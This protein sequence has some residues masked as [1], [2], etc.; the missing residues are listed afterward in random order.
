LQLGENVLCIQT[1]NIN[2]D[3]SDLSCIPYLVFGI[4]DT[5]TVVS[6]TNTVENIVMPSGNFIYH[7]NFTLQFSGEKLI[8]KDSYGKI[9]DK[10]VI[11]S[12]HINN[13]WGR[14]YDGAKKWC[15]FEKPTP[16]E[17][18][19]LSTGYLEYLEPPTFSLLAGFYKCSQLLS[20]K[21]FSEVGEIHYTVDGSAPT[22]LSPV[23]KSPIT[24]D[25]TCVIKAKSFGYPISL[26]STTSTSTYFINENI[27]LPVISLSTNP[28]NLWDYHKGIYVS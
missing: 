15:Y 21:N 4:K 19:N 10:K 8:L 17:T 27:S 22:L 12:M 16:Y 2:N 20:L 23:Y 24:I 5:T 11:K 1:H 6:Q 3:S 28:E 18:N 9:A 26:P 14:V 25:S 13:S 7:A